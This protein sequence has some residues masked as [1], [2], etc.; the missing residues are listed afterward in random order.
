MLSIPRELWSADKFAVQFNNFMKN[1]INKK[2]VPLWFRVWQVQK[3]GAIHAHILHFV[4]D[5]FGDSLWSGMGNKWDRKS[6]A[7]WEAIRVVAAGAQ[8]YGF[9]FNSSE[10]LRVLPEHAKS[11][12]MFQE[13]AKA[14]VKYLCRYLTGRHLYEEAE[15]LFGRRC[16]AFSQDCTK[17]TSQDY[18]SCDER[19]VQFCESVGIEVKDL[20]TYAE[21]VY[22]GFPRHLAIK[23]FWQQ[24]LIPFWEAR[25][26]NPF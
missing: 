7:C 18:A 20:N 26:G 3:R 23:F 1:F 24:H 17:F 9:G 4:P 22:E 14:A 5:C 12:A 25:K 16:Y 8:K 2:L 15:V 6:D 13:A 21:S 19:R 10:P 11:L